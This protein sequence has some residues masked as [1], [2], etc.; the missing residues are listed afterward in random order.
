[1]HAMLVLD[2]SPLLWLEIRFKTKKCN[3]SKSERVQISFFH[4]FP[5]LILFIVWGHIFGLVMKPFSD[6]TYKL[7]SYLSILRVAQVSSTFV[8]NQEIMYRVLRLPAFV[9]PERLLA[10]IIT[11]WI[12]TLLAHAKSNVVHLLRQR[13][14]QLL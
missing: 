3:K 8:L 13:F 4:A 1:M 2:P 7:F 6:A 9:Q 10:H 11:D 12:Q 14:Q 5:I